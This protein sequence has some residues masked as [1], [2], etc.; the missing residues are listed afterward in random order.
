MPNEDFGEE[1]KAVVQVAPGVE[2]SDALAS[3]LI[4]FCKAR[5]AGY[6]VPRSVEFWDELP[7]L[8]TGKLYKNEI[9]KHY[10]PETGKR[11]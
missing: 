4:E 1:V 8:P 6:M 5:L 11:I 2:G 7:R 9:R 3:Q 10:W